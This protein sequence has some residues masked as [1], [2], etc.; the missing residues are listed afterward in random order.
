MKNKQLAIRIKELRNRRGISQEEL[1]ESTGLSLRTI[2]R[3][4]NG[5]SEPRGD[6][7]KRLA[8]S[9]EVTPD[10]IIVWAMHEDRG[11]LMAVNLSALSVVLVPLLGIL[12]PL[13]LWISKKDKIKDINKI[14]KSVI[15]FQISWSLIF[16]GAFVFIVL[17]TT[18]VFDSIEK[19][20]II[21]PEIVQSRFWNLGDLKIFVLF[22]TL[23]LLYNITLIIINTLRIKKKKDVRYFPI[24]RFLR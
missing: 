19:N 18:L 8:N 2:Q 22:F 10:E 6:S 20:G 15:N 12:F 4:E 21:T 23:M 14:S 17:R 13:I 1:S 16:H 9:F 11:F 5:E 3:I 7:L 24:I